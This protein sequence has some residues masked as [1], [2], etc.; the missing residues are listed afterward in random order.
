VSLFILQSIPPLCDYKAWIDTER[1]AEA[2]RY[3]RTMAR[4]N[5]IEEFR[6]CRMEERKRAVY[7]A[8]WHEMD[9]EQDKEKREEERADIT[10]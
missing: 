7:I 4:L 10:V 5:M 9:R 2:I 8:I 1:D 3:L 6:A